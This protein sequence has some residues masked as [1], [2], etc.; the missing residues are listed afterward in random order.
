MPMAWSR[1]QRQRTSAYRRRRAIRFAL[2]IKWKIIHC[3]CSR[4]LSPVPDR[5]RPTSS[6]TS[7]SKPYTKLLRRKIHTSPQSSIFDL[8]THEIRTARIIPITTSSEPFTKPL[9]RSPAHVGEAASDIYRGTLRNLSYESSTYPDSC[10]QDLR[11]P[12]A[13]PCATSP[14][15]P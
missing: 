8:Q 14:M 6:P 3:E 5:F 12:H 2:A 4:Y 15:H 13:P 9:M 1:P 10:V 11:H 7:V